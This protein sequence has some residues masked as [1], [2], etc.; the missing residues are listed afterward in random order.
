[1]KVKAAILRE[2]GRPAPFFESKPITIEDVTL[3][4]PQPTDVVVKVAGGGLC[5]TDL[6]VI[7]GTRARGVPLA[8]GH[9]GSGEIVEVG[10]AVGDVKVGDVVVFQFSPSCGRC[11]R[12]L[13]GRPQL[14]E[15]GEKARAVGELISGGSR[16]RGAGGEVI[17]HQSG[18]S[19]FAEYVV[20]NRGSVV[21]IDDSI[22]AQDAAVF[23]C[24]VMTGVGALVNSARV[25]VGESVA[26]FGLGGVG[27]CGVMGAAAAGADPIIAIDIDRR[28]LA[29]ALEVGATHAFDARGADLVSHILDL[30]GGG[31]DVAVDLAGALE[32]MKTAYAITASGGRLVSAGLTAFGSQFAFEQGDLVVKEKSIIGSFMGSC[33]PVRDIPRFLKMYRHGALPVNKLIDGYV[34][35]DDLNAAFDRLASGE[36]ARQILL[37]HGP[38]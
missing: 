22:S 33:V 26:I 20:V 36:V 15:Q 19:C 8:L 3:L 38:G 27:L 37:P 31:V 12:C 18:L 13:S 9:E 14:C 35:F 16:I 11:Q 4:P 5:R 7:Q 1:M 28:K 2:L 24:A 23:G 25:S 30:T 17:R 6:S 29:K 21:V 32:A 10:S 34:G